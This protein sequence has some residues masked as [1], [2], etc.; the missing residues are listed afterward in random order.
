MICSYVAWP[1]VN[2]LKFERTYQ[3][4]PLAQHVADAGAHYTKQ[5]AKQAAKVLGTVDF[6]GNPL[7][8]LND[9]SAGLAELVPGGDLGTFAKSLTH[10]L[11]DTA[12][13]VTSAI[14]TAIADDEHATVSNRIASLSLFVLPYTS[15][16]GQFIL[17]S[18]T[19]HR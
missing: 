5:L 19:Q 16:G 11:S 2:L 3:C 13:K 6:L 18:G 14:S 15:K 17:L 8:L 12:A 9:M 10:G 7:G 1:Q 4:R